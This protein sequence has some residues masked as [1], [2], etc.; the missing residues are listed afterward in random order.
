MTGPRQKN[1]PITAAKPLIL[2]VAGG[3]GGVGTSLLSACVAT[4][5]GES[6]PRER[7]VLLV[8]LDFDVRGLTFLCRPDDKWD[9]DTRDMTGEMD[10]VQ[11]PQDVV[12]DSATINNICFIP[13]SINNKWP[14]DD[15]RNPFRSRME[16]ARTIKRILDVARD[17][18][19]EVI[20]FDLG[21]GVHKLHIAIAELGVNFILVAENDNVSQ[22]AALH[23]RDSLGQ[24]ANNVYVLINKTREASPV[25]SIR[26]V[27]GISYLPPVPFDDRLRKKYHAD[28][29]ALL[30][31]GFHGTRYR[32]YVG[33]AIA[34]LHDFQC[35]G[36]NGWD[37]LFGNQ[38]LRLLGR[39]FLYGIG[40]VVSIVMMTYFFVLIT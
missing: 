25:S 15:T 31:S 11:R 34:P 22:C 9:D 21:S 20:V 3:K 4:I 36:P 30:R 12:T 2:A 6:R 40:F 23:I 13:C 28:A 33:R 39:V 37:Y 16:I 18:C 32:K 7:S 35:K 14:T 1:R 5:A 8:D 27:S 17:C 29:R 19:S 24:L 38:G 10:G 26:D